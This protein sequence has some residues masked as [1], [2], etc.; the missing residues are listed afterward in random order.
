MGRVEFLVVR[1][2]NQRG[3]QQ[4][5]KTRIWGGLSECYTCDIWIKQSV[6][7]KNNVIGIVREKLGHLKMWEW[8]GPSH[9]MHMPWPVGRWGQHFLDRKAWRGMKMHLIGSWNYFCTGLGIIY[10]SI[11]SWRR[12]PSRRGLHGQCK[13]Q[14]FDQWEG[15]VNFLWDMP[16][17]NLGIPCIHES[18]SISWWQGQGWKPKMYT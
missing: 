5:S 13:N 4:W 3:S 6:S 2:W 10:R 17:S 16:Y 11:Y 9:E 1:W 12:H 15:W 8:C 7:Q 18:F 14:R